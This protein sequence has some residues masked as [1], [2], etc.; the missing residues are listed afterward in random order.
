VV[1]GVLR[2][3]RAGLVVEVPATAGDLAR[4]LGAGEAEYAGVA[5]VTASPDGSLTPG[6]PLHVFVNPEVLGT[7]EARGAQVVMSHEAT[8]VATRAPLS[9]LPLWLLEGFADYVALRAVP[10]PLSTTAA[11]VIAQ[12]REEGVPATLPGPT[13]FDPT[14]SHLGAAYEAAWLACVVLADRGGEQALVDFYRAA[15]RGG[16]VTALRRAF[17]W[18]LGRLTEVWRARLRDVAS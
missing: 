5:A 15:D 7:L 10:L 17:G 3:W 12:V 16:V 8:H 14:A 9:T 4:A 18:S 2:G 11:Q 1:R 6:A 13:E